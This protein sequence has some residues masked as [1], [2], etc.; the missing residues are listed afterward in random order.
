MASL[1]MV[2]TPNLVNKQ[3]G[4]DFWAVESTWSAQLFA[5]TNEG[6]G[7][8]NNDDDDVGG[9]GTCWVWTCDCGKKLITISLFPSLASFLQLFLPQALNSI[10]R[11]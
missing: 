6:A 3:R 8:N 4:R 9:V 2:L 1:L 7:K 5:A 11:A 10:G